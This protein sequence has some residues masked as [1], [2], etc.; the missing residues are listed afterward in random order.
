[1]SE[2]AKTRNIK[3]RQRGIP[4]SNPLSI[5]RSRI[6]LRYFKVCSVESLEKRNIKTD[7]SDYE[8]SRSVKLK[9]LKT[10]H[11][12]TQGRGRFRDP[13]SAR[14]DFG[15][16][17]PKRYCAIEYG[18]SRFRIFRVRTKI[19]IA[20]ELDFVAWSALCQHGFDPGA[21]FDQAVWVEII[22]KSFSFGN[23][24]RILI[25]EQAIV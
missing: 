19:T 9:G 23:I 6:G 22:K 5:P 15:P 10:Q 1:L 24:F 3:K 11:Q 14:L 4:K 12:K 2:R 17:I 7:A 21:Q 13:S 25:Q 16:S 20:F 18:C 8:S